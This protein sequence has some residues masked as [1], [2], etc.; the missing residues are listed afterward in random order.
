MASSALTAEATS[1]RN[2][3]ILARNLSLNKILIES[4]SLL[5]VQALKSNNIGGESEPILRHILDWMKEV[6][7]GGLTWTPGR[8]TNW[9][10]WR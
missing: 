2:A 9:H 3:V 1:I 10:T 4:D 7:N 5:M 8:G 6:E